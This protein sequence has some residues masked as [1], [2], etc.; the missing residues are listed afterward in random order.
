MTTV[1]NIGRIIRCHRENR[2]YTPKI[3]V[4]RSGELIEPGGPVPKSSNVFSV[5]AVFDMNLGE[6]NYCVS[7]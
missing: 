2:E 5:A 3:T 4:E 1:Q 7:T 6:L